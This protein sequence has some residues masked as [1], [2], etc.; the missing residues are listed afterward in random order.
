MGKKLAKKVVLIGW[1]AADWKLINPLLDLGMMPNL[2]RMINDGVMGN[3]ATLDPPMSPTLWTAIATGKRPY[4]HGVHGFTEPDTSGEAVRPIYI[5]AR[6]VRAIWNMLTMRNMKCH[7]VG[8]WPSHPAEPIN[9]ISISNFFQKSNKNP[10]DWPLAPGTV[11]P[12]EKADFYASLRVHTKELTSAHLAPFLS[13]MDTIDTK[14]P[15]Y[16]KLYGSINSITSDAAS[17]HAAATHVMEHEDYDLFCVYYDAIDHYGHGFMKYHPPY[18]EHLPRDMYDLFNNVN[19]AGYRYHDMLLG[20]LLDLAGDDAIVMLVSDHGFHPDHLRPTKLPL[21]DEPAAPALEHSP[22]GIIVAKGPGIKQDERIYGA[23]LLDIT[24]TILPILGLPVAK[25]FDGKVLMNIFEEP[26]NVEVIDSWEDEEGYDGQHKEEIEVDPD[27]AKASL[28]QLIDLGYIEDP[29]PNAQA[30][31]ERTIMYNKYFLARAYVNGGKLLDALPLFE[32]LWEENRDNSRFGIRLVNT[33][34]G[35]E[36]LQEARKVADEVF[37]LNLTDTPNLRI[38]DGTILMKEQKYQ[39]AL[40][41]FNAAFEKN[42]EAAG[43]NLLLARNYN[44][45]RRFQK[46][47]EAVNRELAINYENPEAHRILGTIFM[48]QGAFEKAAESFLNAI[49]LRYQFP[50][51]HKALGDCLLELG[52]YDRAAEA[53]QVA[54]SMFPKF[55]QAREKLLYIYNEKLKNPSHAQNIKE[56]LE[57][58][59]KIEGTIHIVTGLRRAGT[60]LVMRMLNEGG[61]DVFTDEIKQADEHNPHGYFE[62]EFIKDIHHNRRKLKEIKDAVVKIPASKI[63]YLPAF[64]RYKVININRKLAD[65]LDSKL[66]VANKQKKVIGLFAFEKLERTIARS[67]K[68]FERRS[69]VEELQL[70]YEDIIADPEKTAKQMADFLGKELDI[71]KM[72]AAVDNDLVERKKKKE[73]VK[74]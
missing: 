27:E 37:E 40:E 63:G 24:P 21:R 31:I 28:Q 65:I 50:L 41:A 12:E 44:N 55:N 53:Y 5:T 18:R 45:L 56:E 10:N 34:L 26:I 47:F 71:D 36:M 7:Q 17:I 9:G 51:A 54:L 73:A 3:L 33:Y 52:I 29:G 70:N 4:K 6:K 11:H 22:Y 61:M 69:E 2:E 68:W 35:L 46:A 19:V 1:D 32:E 39:K 13:N 62:H 60:S 48:R 72:I 49:G 38:L 57:E 43:L 23:S 67:R 25:D 14:N 42:P 8:W 30:A 15:K 58:L 66:A 64:F 20:R 59:T 74:E 16:Q